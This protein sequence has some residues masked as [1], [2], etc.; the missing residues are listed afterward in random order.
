VEDTKHLGS[1]TTTTFPQGARSCTWHKTST[2]GGLFFEAHNAK[3][4]EP[5]L[6]QA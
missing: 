2:A 4:I 5:H 3:A 6:G 1:R